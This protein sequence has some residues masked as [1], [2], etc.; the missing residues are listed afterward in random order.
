MTPPTD[1]FICIDCKCK[2]IKEIKVGRPPKRCQNC[3]RLEQ[4]RV[5]RLKTI[6]GTRTKEDPEVVRQRA[7][8][9]AKDNKERVNAK[10]RAWA[11][12]NKE[13]KLLYIRKN[14]GIVNATGE[15][16]SGCCEI[17]GTHRGSLHMD[18]CHSTGLIR[19]WLCFTCNTGIGSLKDDKALLQNAISYLVR[20]NKKEL[21][22]A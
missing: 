7:S 4:N 1:E 18:H 2:I 22:Y 21:R 16:K 14:H 8:Q 15:T 5:S 19:G 11:N 12:A 9:W 17:C 3:K 10:N 13:K 6:N 20:H